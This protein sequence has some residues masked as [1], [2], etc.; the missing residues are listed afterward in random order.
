[1]STYLSV[2][3]AARRLGVSPHTVRRWTTSGFLPCTRTAGGH[4]RIKLEDIDELTHLIGG[5]NHLAARLARERDLESLVETALLL[6]GHAETG[7]LLREVARRLATLL[8]AQRCVVSEYDPHGGSLA[9]LAVHDDLDDG[10]DPAA[11]PM[12]PRL[13]AADRALARRESVAVVA[14]DPRADPTDVAVM[15]RDGARS[16]LLVPAM[17]G[18]EVVGLV[19]VLDR[20]RERRFG[21]Q[22]VRLAAA[23][24]VQAA[25]AL[26]DVRLSARLRRSVDDVAS[27]RRAVETVT[28][29]RHVLLE[30]P[31]A[32]GVLRAAARLAAD[33]LDGLTCVAQRGG[34]TAGASGAAAASSAPRTGSAHVLATSAPCGDRPL[35]LT[36]TLG[37][38]AD[39]GQR[40]MLSLIAGVAAGAL[41]ALPGSDPPA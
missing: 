37:R 10:R 5:R 12:P 15:R 29:G 28:R 1:M 7:E 3:L 6:R 26:R 4:R 41:A 25:A 8:E 14:S 21:R 18:G 32:A 16:L 39:E 30:E 19:E 36:L 34:D 23:V 40:E 35:T 27:L 24:A 9:V 33:A 22:E 11:P 13:P 17:C 31:T 38:P 20:L 2:Q